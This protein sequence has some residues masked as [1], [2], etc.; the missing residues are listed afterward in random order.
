MEE[1]NRKWV[2]DNNVEKNLWKSFTFNVNKEPTPVYKDKTTCL[3]TLQLVNVNK[4]QLQ[5]IK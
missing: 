3:L 2:T 4:Y 5:L 1:T